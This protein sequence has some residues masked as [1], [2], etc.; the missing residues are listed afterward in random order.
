M[1][2][3]TVHRSE[4]SNCSWS[5]HPLYLVFRTEIIRKIVNCCHIMFHYVVII[6]LFMIISGVETNCSYPLLLSPTA[7][8]ADRRR[9]NKIYLA[10]FPIIMMVLSNLMMAS[11]IINHFPIQPSEGQFCLLLVTKILMIRII[12]FDNS[13]SYNVF[14]LIIYVSSFL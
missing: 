2:L 11:N 10:L 6:S 3:T 14:V 9:V 13:K 5:P 4:Q 7:K 8:L 12:N 1:F